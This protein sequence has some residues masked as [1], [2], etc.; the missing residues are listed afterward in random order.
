MRAAS[1][2]CPHPERATLCGSYGSCGSCC[3]VFER[4]VLVFWKLWKYWK[5]PSGHVYEAT[6]EKAVS[7]VREVTIWNKSSGFLSYPET[8]RRRTNTQRQTART[9]RNPSISQ[10]SSVDCVGYFHYFQNVHNGGG[11]ESS[12]MDLRRSRATVGLFISSPRGLV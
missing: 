3:P 5:P 12:F 8:N 1:V 11:Q 2:G 10:H 9:R 7:S 4:P 6:S